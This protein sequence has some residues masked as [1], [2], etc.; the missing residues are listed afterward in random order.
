MNK[1]CF[2]KTRVHIKHSERR[3]NVT[4]LIQ[5][6]CLCGNIAYELKLAVS[7]K[8]SNIFFVRPMRFFLYIINTIV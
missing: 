2:M 1:F 3:F 6:C 8:A 5:E 7:E 4:W